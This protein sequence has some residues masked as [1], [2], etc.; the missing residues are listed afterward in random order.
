MKDMTPLPALGS[1]SPAFAPVVLAP[2]TPPLTCAR[3]LI[4][5]RVQEMVK[6]EA[7]TRKGE[8]L[9]ALHDMRVW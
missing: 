1:A 2:E 5:E 7:G 6:F 3:Q 9:E 8:D 4:L